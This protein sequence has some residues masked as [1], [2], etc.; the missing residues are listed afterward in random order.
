MA[1]LFWNNMSEVKVSILEKDGSELAYPEEANE[2][3]K[4]LASG[5]KTSGTIDF[6]DSSTA[7]PVTLN[8]LLN[9]GIFPRLYKIWALGEMGS[10]QN[11]NSVIDGGS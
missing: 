10:D 6:E 5:F 2:N 3:D 8:E 4:I 1:P 7:S 11:C 9:S